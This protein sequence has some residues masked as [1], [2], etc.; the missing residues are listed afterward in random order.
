ML[1]I[2]K[3]TKYNVTVRDLHS[4]IKHENTFVSVYIDT[5]KQ[6]EKDELSSKNDD[7]Y[8][9]RC[10]SEPSFN[11]F[12][13][14]KR[15][16]SKRKYL[17]LKNNTHDL[18]TPDKHKSEIMDKIAFTNRCCI[19]LKKARNVRKHVYVYTESDKNDDEMV[20]IDTYKIESVHE[21]GNYHL[22]DKHKIVR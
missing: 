4:F 8:T 19:V 18:T 3:H 20:D 10:F 12:E 22:E 5:D 14:E 7:I 11:T 2:K 9:L 13:L 15:T 1:P 21:E 6:L 16:G 17:Y